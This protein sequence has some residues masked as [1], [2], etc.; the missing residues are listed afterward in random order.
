MG[1][2]GQPPAE[3]CLPGRPEW[4]DPALGSQG[5]ASQQ[6]G[7]RGLTWGWKRREDG[8]RYFSF[9]T[10]TGSATFCFST[11]LDNTTEGYG[12]HRAAQG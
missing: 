5:K 4:T 2:R 9:R 1:A 8:R 12:P 11:L 10:P 6:R 7:A 3:A